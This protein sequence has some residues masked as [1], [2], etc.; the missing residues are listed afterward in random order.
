MLQSVFANLLRVSTAHWLSTTVY[1]LSEVVFDNHV[2]SRKS[3]HELS[4]K[5]ERRL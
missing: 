4:S 5:I 2:M 3:T 1:G